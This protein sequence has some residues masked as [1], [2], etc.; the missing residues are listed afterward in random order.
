MKMSDLQ[1]FIR[2][3]K[4]AAGEKELYKGPRRNKRKLSVKVSSHDKLFCDCIVFGF[5]FSI[6]SLVNDFFA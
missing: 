6:I 3:G 5:F 2:Y 1:F 4:L